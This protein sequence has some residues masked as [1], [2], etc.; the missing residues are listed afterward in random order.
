MRFF[1]M[2]TWMNKDFMGVFFFFQLFCHLFF[3]FQNLSVPFLQAKVFC[4]CPKARA[5]SHTRTSRYENELQFQELCTWSFSNVRPGGAGTW[6]GLSCNLFRIPHQ[7][8]TVISDSNSSQTSALAYTIFCI[9]S[10]RLSSE[11]FYFHQFLTKLEP[12]YQPFR[13]FL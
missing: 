9:S 3:F 12:S 13:S 6:E 8:F 10:A 2:T 1:I 5:G 7:I 4:L 11:L